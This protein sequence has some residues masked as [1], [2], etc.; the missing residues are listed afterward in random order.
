VAVFNRDSR[1]CFAPA[2]TA[3]RI[4]MTT[5]CFLT[6]RNRTFSYLLYQPFWANKP[7]LRPAI[8]E[9]L[10]VESNESLTYHIAMA[11][12][13]LAHYPGSPAS[14]LS[15][16][17]PLLALWIFYSGATISLFFE[18]SF[19]CRNLTCH[20]IK[21][22]CTQLQLYCHHPGPCSAEQTGVTNGDAH[23]PPRLGN[24]PVPKHHTTGLWMPRVV[25]IRL[26]LQNQTGT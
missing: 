7:P 26:L 6:S 2:N 16:L 22:A 21:E 1:I 3:L 4:V 8:S 10:S 11:L 13:S 23:C 5:E 20:S 18:P 12:A 9:Y 19:P 25:Q 15:L 24:S 17:I 14:C